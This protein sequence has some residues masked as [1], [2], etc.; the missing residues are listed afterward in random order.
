MCSP[1][2]TAIARNRVTRPVAIISERPSDRGLQSKEHC[3][4]CTPSP[5][6]PLQNP[7]A[8][9][10][11]LPAPALPGLNRLAFRRRRPSAPIRVGWIPVP[12]SPRR[13]EFSERAAGRDTRPMLV[14]RARSVG[15]VRCVIHLFFPF[16]FPPPPTP[17]QATRRRRVFPP[18]PEDAHDRRR[19]LRLASSGEASLMY[20]TRQTPQTTV[21]EARTCLNGPDETFP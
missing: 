18:Y 20:A 16:F 17:P 19:G 13:V 7:T 21:I 3:T 9:L 2:R 14:S 12:L 10:C 5:L 4:P 1:P 6:S 11:V 15:E 8:D